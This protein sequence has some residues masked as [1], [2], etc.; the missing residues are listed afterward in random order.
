M[1]KTATELPEI[2]TTATRKGKVSAS[3]YATTFIIMMGLWCVFSGRF[4]AFHLSLGVISSV[5][6]SYFSADLLFT[7]PLTAKTLRT[8]IGFIKY[9][10]WLILQIFLAARHLLY[11]SFHPRMLELI[12]PQ[13]IRFR[14]RLKSDL[15]QV[16]FA[17]SITLT[18]GTITVYV[19]FH[20]DF[21]VHAIDRFS[22]EG[23]PGEME[24][25]IAR[26][27]GEE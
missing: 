8:A 6:V 21:S 2:Q 23:L 26:A 27:F 11:L 9:V 3:A 4:D 10:P 25:R 5:M 14:S 12:D 13:V 20:R 24:Q 15:A 22:A 19:N 16:T 7:G 18:P 1:N 17:N